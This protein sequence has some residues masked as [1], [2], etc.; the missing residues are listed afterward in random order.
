[1]KTGTDPILLRLLVLVALLAAS[2]CARAQ[3]LPDPGRRLS[4]EEQAADPEK[5]SAPS[6]AMQAPPG[7]RVRDAKACNNARVNYQL[8][9]GAPGSERSFSRSC[10]EA[11]AIY[12]QSCP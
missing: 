4:K 9:C 6:P 5:R 7:T 11:Y 3:D 8:S 10:G 1:M 2:C 12:R